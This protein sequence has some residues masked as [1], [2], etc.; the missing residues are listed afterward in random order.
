MNLNAK[1]T[2]I[3]VIDVQKGLFKQ[4]KPVY[5]EKRLLINILQIINFARGNGIHLI[6]VQHANKGILKKGSLGWELHPHIEPL[7][8]EDVVQKNNA[9]AF[10]DTNLH[11]LLDKKGIKQLILLGMTTHGCVKATCLD[12]IKIGY[13]V[14]LVEDAHSSFSKNASEL[15]NEWNRKLSEKGII[16]KSCS[17]IVTRKVY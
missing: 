13:D 12:A 17:E 2:A 8:N 1:N 4:K 14:M 3:L 10:N 15:I 16:L 6:F 7:H 11:I 5:N 9:S